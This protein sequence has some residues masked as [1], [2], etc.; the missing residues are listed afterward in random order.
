V[1]LM[2]ACGSEIQMG[3]TAFGVADTMGTLLSWRGW[4]FGDRLTTLGETLPLPPL[5]TL[6][7]GGA[8]G[9]QQESGTQ[10]TDELD[11]RLGWQARAR[12]S[13]PESFLVQAA[14]LDNGGDRQLYHGQYSW[15]TRFGQ[16]G[17]EVHLGRSLVLLGEGAWGNTGMG[18]A[19][20]AHVDVRFRLGYLLLSWGG[21]TARVSV[22]HDRF[23]NEDRD[24]TAEPDGESGYAW[25]VAALWKPHPHVRLGIELQA[26]RADRPAAAYS[27][28]NPDTDA[29]RVL[30]EARLV[31]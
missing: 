15:H 8:F 1:S 3:A 27:G 16:V 9:R 25:T 7:P 4:A 24:G 18:P 23:K 29:S 22:R 14:Y 17:A 10:P 20:A 30:G 2:S 11:H 31:F 19:Q 28:A 26:V 13:R 21:E 12:W 6:G 5:S